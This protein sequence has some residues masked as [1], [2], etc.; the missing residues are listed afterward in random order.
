MTGYF[1]MIKHTRALAVLFADITKSS[2]IYEKLGDQAAQETVGRIL[3]TLSDLTLEKGGSVIKS[4]GDAII[5]TFPAMDN[6]VEAA[7]LMQ[8]AM[9]AHFSGAQNDLP[10]HIH[11]GIQYG[12]VVVE[13]GDIFGDVVNT[14]ARLVDFA[15]PRQIVTTRQALEKLPADTPHRTRYIM[16]I[17]AKNIA[18]ELEL[19]EVVHEEQST[20]TVIDC[21]RLEK[22]LSSSL[23]L[24]RG[25]Q[26]VMVNRQNPLV[27]IGR[28]SFNDIV[29]RHPWISRA[30]AVIENRGGVFLI[31]D[32]S[33][34]G[35]FVYPEEGEPF[36]VSKA[37][38][39]LAGR[40]IIIFG[41]GKDSQREG[42]TTDLI[43]YDIP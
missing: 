37:E 6:A 30:H 28:E 3:S 4:V 41:R 23:H 19:F 7:I 5:A 9:S 40:G 43:S 27:S 1:D 17:T 10:L 11:I 13:K 16:N 8:Q 32:K 2:I 42:E 26:T 21:R 36:V 31:K 29:I 25:A 35:T 12:P 18:G 38:A 15:N 14:T 33:T 24:T 22:I 34:N 39:S 20:T